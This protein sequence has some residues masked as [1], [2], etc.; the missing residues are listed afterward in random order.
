M[1]VY[2]K[3]YQSVLKYLSL[4]DS[5]LTKPYLLRAYLSKLKEP[6]IVLGGVGAEDVALVKEYFPF[7]VSHREDYFRNTFV[8]SK[9]NFNNTDASLVKEIP[10]LN[11]D[12]NVYV[13]TAKPLSFIKDSIYFDIYKQDDEFP[14]NVN[15]PLQKADFKLGQFILAEIS[16]STAKK[17]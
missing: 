9:Q 5:I 13:N 2:E 15:F 17:S 14:F 12:V 16:Y 8:F 11:S 3:K 10:L 1:Y 6:F 7:L 4:K